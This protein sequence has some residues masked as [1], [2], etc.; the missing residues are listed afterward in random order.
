MSS[1][2]SKKTFYLQNIFYCL[3]VV[4]VAVTAFIIETAVTPIR[5]YLS[6]TITSTDAPVVT[7]GIENISKITHQTLEF[8]ID[9]NF[10]GFFVLCVFAAYLHYACKEKKYYG[11]G[12]FTHFICLCMS[13]FWL[14]DMLFV[15]NKHF[16]L[17]T[18]PQNMS[19]LLVA[20]KLVIAMTFATG[21]YVLV[22]SLLKNQPK[23]TE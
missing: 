2:V 10:Y 4:L 11:I 12:L 22:R 21:F 1:S 14:S 18:Q 6:E 9:I 19:V 23:A 20:T 5:P 15:F 13:Y 16:G 3:C 8:V 17:L 7:N